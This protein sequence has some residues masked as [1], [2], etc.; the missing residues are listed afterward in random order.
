M[1][2][3]DTDE[4]WSPFLSLE[5]GYKLDELASDWI[6]TRQYARPVDADD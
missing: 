4:G 2:L 6:L 1:E 5:D 3:I